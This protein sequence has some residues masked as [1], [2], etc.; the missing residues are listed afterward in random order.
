MISLTLLHAFAL[1]LPLED[2]ECGGY[3]SRFTP[4]CDYKVN[5]NQV[6]GNFDGN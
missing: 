1:A 2:Q 6:N 5:D 3:F 4:A